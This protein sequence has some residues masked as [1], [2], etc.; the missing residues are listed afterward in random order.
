MLRLGG[1]DPGNG[2]LYSRGFI[3]AICRFEGNNTM[4]SECIRSCVTSLTAGTSRLNFS[5]SRSS[6]RSRRVTVSSSED[7]FDGGVGSP[8]QAE[9]PVRR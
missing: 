2:H 1:R 8:V 9:S 5:K 6:L 7:G 4:D 3:L